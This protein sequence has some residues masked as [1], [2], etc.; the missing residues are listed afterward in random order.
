MKAHD[1]LPPSQEFAMMFTNSAN[2]RR[3]QDILRTEFIKIA[4]SYP[5]FQI[6]YSVTDRRWNLS[7][8]GDNEQVYDYQCSHVE[9]DSILLYIYLQ[10][11]RKG[12][13]SPVVIDAEDTDV[14]VLAVYVAHTTDGILAL[15]GKRW[16]LTAENFVRERLQKF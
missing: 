11:R 4:Q 9:A 12:D 13:Q 16:L 8:N 7:C 1:T 2:K 15:E 14:V 5:H 10:L 6:L 3:L